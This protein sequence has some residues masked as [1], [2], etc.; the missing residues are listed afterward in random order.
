MTTQNRNY[1][2]LT[3][4]TLIIDQ[5]SVIYQK[6]G[7]LQHIKTGLSKNIIIPGRYAWERLLGAIKV[8]ILHQT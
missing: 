4:I 3:K 8:N 1:I 5:T 6:L 7:M 2:K